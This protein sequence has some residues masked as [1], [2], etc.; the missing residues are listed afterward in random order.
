S[1][2][3]QWPDPRAARRDQALLA[4]HRSLLLRSA[5]SE[6]PGARI[7]VAGT[8]HGQ[9]PGP[10]APTVICNTFLAVVP[11]PV[12]SVPGQPR[13]TAGLRA[14]APYLAG[15]AG[16]TARAHAPTRSGAVSLRRQAMML[17][18]VI[19]PVFGFSEGMFSIVIEN[20]A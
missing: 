4:W 10:A 13:V 6:A 2:S 15:G 12:I 1:Q 19:R 9:S 3:T 17:S 18:A 20:V 7:A 16:P 5:P 8:L 14:H 11:T